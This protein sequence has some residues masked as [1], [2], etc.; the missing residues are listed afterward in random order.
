MLFLVMAPAVMYTLQTK[1]AGQML[2][3][4]YGSKYYNIK[5]SNMS[6]GECVPPSC[7]NYCPALS[8]Y[9]KFSDHL[10]LIL[11]QITVCLGYRP[12][13]QSPDKVALGTPWK[14]SCQ[15]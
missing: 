12:Y 5:P 2:R 3:A 8:H 6:R 15:K 4:V 9:E 10:I 11:N 14:A 1:Q 13:S 7:R